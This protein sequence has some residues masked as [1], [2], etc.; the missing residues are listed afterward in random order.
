MERGLALPRLRCRELAQHVQVRLQANPDDVP[1]M[2]FEPLPRVNRPRKPTKAD[3]R[4]AR[5]FRQ[6]LPRPCRDWLAG[7]R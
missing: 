3:Y 4:L 7:K 1:M 2:L 6:P 5:R